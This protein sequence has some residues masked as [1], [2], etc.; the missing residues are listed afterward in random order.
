[1]TKTEELRE[2]TEQ[3][4]RSNVVKTIINGNFTF[5]LNEGDSATQILKAF[6]DAG[7]VMLSDNQELPKAENPHQA[8]R[9]A[10]K[11]ITPLTE[12]GNIRNLQL[13]SLTTMQEALDSSNLA[14][15]CARWGAFNEASEAH[16]QLLKEAGFRRTEEIVCPG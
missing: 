16:C 14:C 12:L 8:F 1:M 10:L 3:I 6:K 11:R 7:G 15:A 9:D 4:I 13:K 2:E 5:I